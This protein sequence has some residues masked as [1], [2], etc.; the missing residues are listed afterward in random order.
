ML[1][2]P[3]E[4]Q[5]FDRFSELFAEFMPPDADAIYAELGFTPDEAAR[6]PRDVGELRQI[7]D[8]GAVVGFLW[9]EL[10]ERTLH[11]HALLLEPE[12]RGRGLG[13]S[14]LDALERE[15]GGRAD[16]VELGVLPDNGRAIHLY[17]RAGFERAGER[18][19][20]LIMRKRLA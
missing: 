18:L 6:L 4:E 3:L 12:F 8:E 2:R 9:L 16:G 1:A 11:V 19:G 10:R 17:E 13:G 14:V 20:F 7:E 15:F 5:R